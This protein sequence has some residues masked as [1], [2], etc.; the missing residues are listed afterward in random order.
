VTDADIPPGVAAAHERARRSGFTLSCEPAVG[1]LLATLAAAVP[2]GGAIFEMGTGVG[3]G[4][5]WLVH[6]LGARRD[7][8]LIS[9]EA[10]PTTAA[11]AR[12]ATWPDYVSLRVADVLAVLDE[13][14]PFDLIF[15][16]AQGGKWTGL[17]RTIAALRPGGLLLVDD[18][19]PPSWLDDAHRAHTERVRTRL[20]GD[21]LLVSVE[22]ACGS[23]MI[24]AT[25][26][27]DAGAATG[28]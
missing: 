13:I 25:R 12:E 18:M 11:I 8:G 4:S 17:E 3:A 28:S 7:V 15:A 6:G 10:D 23:G 2:P 1:R 26:R 19:T 5:A 24:L 9:V 16:D 27:H 22:L 20:L 14:A 21:P